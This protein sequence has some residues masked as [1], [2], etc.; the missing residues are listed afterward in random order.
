MNS[1]SFHPE[2]VS[3]RKHLRRHQMPCV[4]T[5]CSRLSGSED[6]RHWLGP[7]SGEQS[8]FRGR[9]AWEHPPLQPPPHRAGNWLWEKGPYLCNVPSRPWF[10][11][12]MPV[13]HRVATPTLHW[14][15][16]LASLFQLNIKFSIVHCFELHIQ[17]RS[18]HMGSKLATASRDPKRTPNPVSSQ[19]G[20]G[21]PNSWDDAHPLSSAFAA[22]PPS[23]PP[24]VLQ[25]PLS[26]SFHQ[27]RTSLPPP[28]HSLLT[29]RLQRQVL[30][31]RRSSP[32]ASK[33]DAAQTCASGG[34]AG[35]GVPVRR[36]RTRHGERY[37]SRVPR[38]SHVRPLRRGGSAG[39]SGE[40]CEEPRGCEE[41]PTGAPRGSGHSLWLTVLKKQK[42][43]GVRKDIFLHEL[44]KGTVGRM[45]RLPQSH[46]GL[47]A[48]GRPYL[49]SGLRWS[50]S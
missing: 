47:G 24:E 36:N 16:L 11:P 31:G 40:G 46:Q 42:K 7:W 2:A 34:W 21:A 4:L 18:Q 22:P 41:A 43:P 30:L 6:G 37:D 13:L 32:T 17:L 14:R 45:S 35:C 38:H 26:S 19:A 10:N 5:A 25:T 9:R 48:A 20:P 23:L 3:S 8:G 39:L 1:D 15:A 44:T 33:P 50:R 27:I 12:D 49:E 28:P 29:L